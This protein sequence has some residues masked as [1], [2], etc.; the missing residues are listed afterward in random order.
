MLSHMIRVV[1]TASYSQIL[2]ELTSASSRNLDALCRES[3]DVRA[4]VV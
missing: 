4:D 3:F 1:G 2:C